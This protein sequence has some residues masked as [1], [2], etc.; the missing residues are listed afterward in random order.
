M[1][2]LSRILGQRGEQ[3]AAQFLQRKGYRI[4]GRNFRVRGGE[5]DLV[6]RHGD[7]LVFVEVKTRTAG[8]LGFPEDAVKR[9]KQQR[10]L[11]AVNLYLAQL[12]TPPP[13]YR[14]DVVSIEQLPNGT[15]DI[16]HY[17]NVTA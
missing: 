4:L 10:L 6:C 1:K 2:L 11:R 14:L 7:C 12:P 8:G 9:E 16:V 13:Q 15:T 17:E 5:V 3:T